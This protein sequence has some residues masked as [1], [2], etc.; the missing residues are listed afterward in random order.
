M[1]ASVPPAPG[2]GL[3]GRSRQGEIAANPPYWAP[4]TPTTKELEVVACMRA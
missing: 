4:S 1:S 3:R 2:G